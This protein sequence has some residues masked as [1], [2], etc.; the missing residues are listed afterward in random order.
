M[1]R[2]AVGAALSTCTLNVWVGTSPVMPSKKY[3]SNVNGAVTGASAVAAS[4]TTSVSASA[5]NSPA[6]YVAHA[7]GFFFFFFLASAGNA[8]NTDSARAAVSATA[9]DFFIN[10]PLSLLRLENEC[11]GRTGLD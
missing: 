5:P 1:Y 8:A 7:F 3:G 11:L 9:S 6:T 4:V 2:P 10:W